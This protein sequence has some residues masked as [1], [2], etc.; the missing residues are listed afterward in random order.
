MANL[1][2]RLALGKILPAI[3]ASLFSDSKSLVLTTPL[4]WSNWASN[5]LLR[6]DTSEETS[7]SLALTFSEAIAIVLAIFISLRVIGYLVK[8]YKEFTQASLTL[9]EMIA[10]SKDISS[11]EES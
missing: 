10:S 3:T 8:S 9:V 11:S 6:L 1:T 5:C 2:I 4:S 7:L